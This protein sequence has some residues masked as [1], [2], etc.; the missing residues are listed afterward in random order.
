M[1][2]Q[3]TQQPNRNGLTKKRENKVTEIVTDSG[4]ITLSSQVVRDYLVSGGGA[5][6]DQEIKLF[7]GL[8]AGQK[9]NPFIR[10]AYLI[11]FG[12]KDPAQM[13]VSK[14]VYQKRANKNPNYAGKKTGIVVLGSNGNVEYRE[15][16]LYMEN[17]KILG[18][19]CE[20]YKKDQTAPERIEVSFNEYCGRKKDG[21]L[22]SQWQKKPATM[23]RKVAVTQALREA[24]TEEFQGMYTAEEVGLDDENLDKSPI[25][26]PQK[27]SYQSAPQETINP[28]QFMEKEPVQN[29][30]AN[31]S[32]TQ[33]SVLDDYDPMA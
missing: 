16:A 23:I 10:E 24:F 21:S 28:Y 18:G 7:I 33:A 1:N 19:W 14:D 22:N 12:E 25:D 5:V 26:E 2:N 27:I 13:V 20:V 4:K 11:K 32:Y 31:E 3:L 29:A 17:E 6:T 30:P 15:G 8:C 9:L